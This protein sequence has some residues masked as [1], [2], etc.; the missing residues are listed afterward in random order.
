MI[1]TTF[2]IHLFSLHFIWINPVF[3][4]ENIN[5]HQIWMP[6][7]LA[8]NRVLDIQQ[9]RDGFLW[10]VT[11]KGLNRYDGYEIKTYPKEFNFLLE[12]D[13]LIK[14]KILIDS[15]NTIWTIPATLNPEYFDRDSEKF[16]PLPELNSVMAMVETD[17]EK[18]LFG[19]LS[20]QLHE[21]DPISK[22]KSLILAKTDQEILNLIKNPRKS[23]DVLVL[24]QNE[25]GIFNTENQ[26]YK[27]LFTL[28]RSSDL[29]FS[30]AGLDE[31]GHIWIGTFE[32]GLFQFKLNQGLL[33]LENPSHE[34]SSYSPILDIKYDS[35]G[36][37]W[38]ATYGDGVF[39]YDLGNQANQKFFYQKNKVNSLASNDISSI[40]MDYSGTLW[41]GSLGAGLNFYDPY[42]DKF[43]VLS[44][45]N[46]P[47]SITLENIRAI[48]IDSSNKIWAGSAGNGLIVHD[49][50]SNQWQSYTSSNASQIKLKENRIISLAGDE[51]E[52]WIGYPSE[53]ISILD[54]KTKRIR[55]FDEYSE[56][57]LPMSQIIR[58][59]RDNQNRTWLCTRNEGLIQFNPIEGIKRK[60]SF[61][62]NQNQSFPDNHI[63][64]FIQIGKDDFLI[65]T[66]SKGLFKLNSES[67]SFYGI[68]RRDTT[69][70]SMIITVLFKDKNQRVWVG[71]A[72][73][74]LKILD[75]QT[76]NWL[77]DSS[78][79]SFESAQIHG[80]LDDQ[81]GKIWVSSD[82]G[83]S[84]LEEKSSSNFKITHYSKSN[85]LSSPFY[86]RAYFSSQANELFF[87]GFDRILHFRGEDI[88]LNPISPK[89]SL[90]KIS[91][92][93]VDYSSGKTKKFKAKENNLTFYF[94]SLT[95]SAPE[96]NQYQYRLIGYDDH[97]K[98]QQGSN[99]VNYTNL[100]PGKYEFQVKGSNYDGVWNE[101]PVT[102]TFAI[103]PSWHQTHLAKIAYFLIIIGLFILIYQYLKWRWSMTYKLEIK[104][105]EA[106]RLKEIDQLKSA[107]FSN[108]SH[109]LRTPLTLIMGPTERLIQE[110]ENPVHKSQLNLIHINAKKLEVVTDKI[111]SIRKISAGKAKLK[112]RKGNLGLLI[113]SV[114]VNFYYLS[115]KKNLT[116]QSNIP[117]ITEVWFDSDQ[118]ERILENLLHFII[119]EAKPKSILNFDAAYKNQQVTLNL[120]FIG[121]SQNEILGEKISKN[122]PDSEND[123]SDHSLKL[124]LIEKL[125]DTHQGQ[126][127]LNQENNERNRITIDFSLDKYSYH[128]SKVVDEE[129]W[130]MDGISSAKDTTKLSDQAPKILIVEDNKSLRNF[131]V[132]ELSNTYHIIEASDGKEGIYEAYKHIP[133]LILSDI[134]MPEVDG[135]ALCKELKTNEKTSHIPII[136]LTAKIEEET[137]LM[138]FQLG[139]DDYIQKPFSS[140]QLALRIEKLIELRNR[141]RIR[142]S[143]GTFISPKEIAVSSTDEK[144]LQKIQEI[145]DSDFME[146]D[147]SVDEFCQKLGMSRMQLHR[148]LTALTGLSTSAF[149]RDQRLRKAIQKLEKTDETV[150][151]IAYSVGFSSPSYFIKCFKET[152]QMT[153]LEYQ[154]SKVN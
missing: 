104:N 33:P 83:I 21:W 100:D 65:A 23:D 148:K 105:H 117:L 146:S 71:T 133:D 55:H 75:L 135:L 35:A 73:Q 44:N 138:G 32:H 113:Q 2:F 124:K 61:H 84:S 56:P 46:A 116:I 125:I 101:I 41:L 102:Y 58:I 132:R 26:E 99:W 127:I 28:P 15:K 89:I 70:N 47:N 57:G 150:A 131:L 118:M 10:V 62:P 128:P 64:D 54:L 79:E 29:L 130:E 63:T 106:L 80:I 149:I 141:L 51:N 38:W 27:S 112:I 37:I 20:G 95:F 137:Q 82:L 126:L 49:Q 115:T 36:H 22:T 25:F 145:V 13:L 74:G 43:Q 108:I 92:G 40:Y 8:N 136:L 87:G 16:I 14:G 12:R 17:A 30:A 119:E 5:F 129:E 140:R 42:L 153:P 88:K 11:E 114:I 34:S 53:G 122:D 90:T 39:R 72:N 147:F 143:Q 152:Y 68:S 52:L 142:Y 109:E 31:L 98:T 96:K 111:L 50:K 91:N 60:F 4:Q 151:E 19:T 69:H 48:W 139:A 76:E 59:Y 67:G 18:L 103:L 3:S 93:T 94:A 66:R 1:K 6:E 120:S 110:C 144:F 123:L 77:D 78:L 85:H 107:F 9:D 24:F 97:W 7:G 121:N 81:A 86:P 45:S 134:M 154:Q